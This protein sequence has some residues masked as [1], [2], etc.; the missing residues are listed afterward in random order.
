MDDGNRQL[1]IS[2]G[3]NPEQFEALDTKLGGIDGAVNKLA[4][5]V[6]SPDT[7]LA[8][9]ISK[10]RTEVVAQLTA[11]NESNAALAQAI[12]AAS[13]NLGKWLAAIALAAA[14]PDNNSK[15]VQQRIDTITNSVKSVKDKLQ[16]SVDSQKG[17]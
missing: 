6:S 7:D 8:A 13:E 10:L 9:E 1:A 17:D 5:N 14:N 4:E 3:L 2:L 16:T 12:T 11:S 15:E